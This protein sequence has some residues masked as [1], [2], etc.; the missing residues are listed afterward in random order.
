M[1]CHE[2]DIHPRT[3]SI[4][5]HR[6][7]L[8]AS[9]TALSDPLAWQFLVPATLKPAATQ[10]LHKRPVV[11][12]CKTRPGARQARPPAESLVSHF[13]A[14]VFSLLLPLLLSISGAIFSFDPAGR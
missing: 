13:S 7:F 2:I 8:P 10:R 11:L 3:T 9:N 14:R 12:Y 6:H 1:P 4:S 5:I